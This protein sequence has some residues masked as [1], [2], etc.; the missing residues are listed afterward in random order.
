MGAVAAVGILAFTSG[1]SQHGAGQGR[2]GISRH[3]K[4]LLNRVEQPKTW[5]AW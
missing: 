5:R 2:E 1:Y 4:S 3:V